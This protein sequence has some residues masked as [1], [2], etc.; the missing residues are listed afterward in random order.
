MID[1][2]YSDP[3][4]LQHHGVKG[5]KWG[6]RRYQRSEQGEPYVQTTKRGGGGSFRSKK[7]PSFNRKTLSPSLP[8]SLRSKSINVVARVL[9][10][11]A[12]TPISTISKETMSLS[13]SLK[14]LLNNT[15][16]LK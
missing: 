1:T 5:M 12:S 10:D 11:S 8:S 3:N 7:K 14:P 9:N 6:V 2:I 15:E 13:P 16:V 4:F